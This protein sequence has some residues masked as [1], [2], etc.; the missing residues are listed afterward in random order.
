MTVDFETLPSIGPRPEHHPPAYGRPIR[1][2]DGGAYAFA[3]HPTGKQLF[4]SR[5]P[6]RADRCGRA[7]WTWQVPQRHVHPAVAHE[8]FGLP[9]PWQR[10]HDTMF[11]PFLLDPLRPH[12]R[13][14]AVG[15]GVARDAA[16]GA[17]RGERVDSGRI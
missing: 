13:T 11:P 1:H 9:E 3:G 5:T 6:A 14:E 12:A 17:R 8:H 4:R 16:R 2:P 10:V 15:T 7:D